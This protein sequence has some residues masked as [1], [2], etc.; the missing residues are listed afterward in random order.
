[1][2]VTSN[3]NF[4]VFRFLAL[5][6]IAA[7]VCPVASQ[8]ATL[9]Y[10]EQP[11]NIV[12][13]SLTESLS[14]LNKGKTEE[15]LEIISVYIDKNP[16]SAPAHEILGI[17][18]TRLGKLKEGRKAFETAIA[19][20]TNQS[21]AYTKL[22]SIHIALGNQA[23]AKEYLLKALEINP[24][25]RQAHQRLGTI[26]EGEGNV[27]EAIYHYEQGLIG[28]NK[29]YLGTKLNLGFLYNQTGLPQ[30]TILL[31]SDWE[32][33]TKASPLV[34]MALA[35]AFLRTGN[36]DKAAS[37]YKIVI[38]RDPENQ[39]A[40]M[41]LGAA[42]RNLKN[43]EAAFAAFNKALEIDENS[44]TAHFQIANLYAEQQQHDKAMDHYLAAFKTSKN[45]E[46]LEPNLA[47][48][49]V[50]V[51][52]IESAIDIYSDRVRRSSATFEDFENLGSLYQGNNDFSSAEAVFEEATKVYPD[53]PEGYFRLGSVYGLQTNYQE[54]LSV[55]TSALQKFPEDTYLL[56][57]AS[58]ASLRLGDR[59]S[60]ISYSQKNVDLHPEIS[61]N[62]FFLAT[63]HDDAGNKDQAAAIYQEIIGRNENHAFAKNNLAVILAEKGDLE[64]ALSL[65]MSAADLAGNNADV[66]HTLGWVQLEKKLYDNA[67]STLEQAK[68]LRPSSA[69]IRF[70]LARSYLAIGQKE[71]AKLQLEAALELPGKFED[72]EEAEALLATL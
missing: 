48:A 55:Y 20:D 12:D 64:T 51:G 39:Q 24:N 37:E 14:L 7:F 30:K 65:A 10:L 43:I 59:K 33:N 17:A 41:G 3:I 19:L 40:F 45:P 29:H 44:S 68:E 31:L 54:A 6:F 46:L 18:L 11:E 23:Q 21:T 5:I 25:A 47:R 9:P 69:V 50:A 36:S 4:K 42:E 62:K 32:G 57:G 13:R 15:A 2:P 63:L 60:A 72:R 67:V 28:T 27:E 1:M 8:S 26:Y 71:E 56:K 66:L 16:D 70:D 49:Y 58:I 61:G 52:E 35:N 53:R 22:A 38:D 34:H